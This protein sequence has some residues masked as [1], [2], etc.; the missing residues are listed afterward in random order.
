MRRKRKGSG[1]GSEDR[2][3]AEVRRA[4]QMRRDGYREQALRVHPW[5]CTKC[6]REFTAGNLHLLTVHHK[7]HDHRNNPPDGS[8]WELLCVHCHDDEHGR[9]EV[10]AAYEGKRADARGPASTYRPFAGLD[11]LL[12]EPEDATEDEDESS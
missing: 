3:A 4:R 2:V 10:A 5:I 7:D 9:R 1:S 6:A 12:R 11:Q 8:N